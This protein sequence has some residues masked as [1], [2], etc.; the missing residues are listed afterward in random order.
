MGIS[1]SLYQHD[2]TNFKTTIGTIGKIF[3]SSLRFIL[4]FFINFHFQ[5]QVVLRWSLKVP[6]FWLR[7]KARQY[8]L[9][10]FLFQYSVPCSSTEWVWSTIKL[11]TVHSQSSA[12]WSINSATSKNLETP[13][14]EPGASC[15]GAQTLPMCNVAPPSLGP[16]CSSLSQNPF[17]LQ[18]CIVSSEAAASVPNEA[19]EDSK[20]N[21]RLFSFCLFL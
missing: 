19:A 20:K 11:G 2:K 6:Q 21:P 14:I 10:S 12:L 1:E 8:G 13:S 3:L 9:R 5:N 16:C 4:Q 15:C 17:S 7:P 18:P